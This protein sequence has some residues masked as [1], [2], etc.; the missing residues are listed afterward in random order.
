MNLIDTIGVLL[1]L[2]GLVCVA[3]FSPEAVRL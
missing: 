2:E 1:K 3:H